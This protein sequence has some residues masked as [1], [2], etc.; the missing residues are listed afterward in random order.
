MV[1]IPSGVGTFYFS[2]LLH[3]FVA[4]SWKIRYYVTIRVTAKIL[5]SYLLRIYICRFLAVPADPGNRKTITDKQ[6]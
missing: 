5:N 4:I 2:K 3:C 6:K 1:P